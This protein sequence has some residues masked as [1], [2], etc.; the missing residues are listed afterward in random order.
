MTPLRLA[1]AAVLLLLAACGGDE[2]APEPVPRA[3]EERLAA[4]KSAQEDVETSMRDA[5]ARM[6]AEMRAATGAPADSAPRR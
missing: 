1:P 4:P 6:D 5:Q 3:L 2:P